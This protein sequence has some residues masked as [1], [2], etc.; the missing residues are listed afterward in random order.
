MVFPTCGKGG[1]LTLA[2]NYWDGVKT[3]NKNASW[4][5]EGMV[6]LWTAFLEKRE[7]IDGV[8]TKWMAYD[9]NESPPAFKVSDAERR[10]CLKDQGT[11]SSQ[12]ARGKKCAA[13]LAPAGAGGLK[14]WWPKKG[15]PSLNKPMSQA[16]IDKAVG[17]IMPASGST[18]K[19]E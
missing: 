19:N 2:K 13:L 11:H 15:A 18:C 5:V 3:F 7:N 1:T 12:A 10:T 14:Y 8:L 4:A 6:D 9:P 17:G 16:S